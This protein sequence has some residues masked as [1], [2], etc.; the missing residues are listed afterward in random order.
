MLVALAAGIA[1]GTA[2]V[3]AGHF[4]AVASSGLLVERGPGV[5]WGALALTIL[6]AVLHEELLFRGYAFQKLLAWRPSAAI[7]ASSVTF[8]ALH[9]GNRDVGPIAL[10]NIALAGVLLALTFL[11]FRS[12]WAPIGA[13]LAWNVVSG[14]ILGHEVSGWDAPATLFETFDPGPAWI[15]G[16][17]FG[18]EGS[19]WMT[20]VQI[21]GIAALAWRIRNGPGFGPVDTIR[22]VTQERNPA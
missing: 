19:V 22:Y 18:I 7:V 12:L 20:L 3:V 1:I 10:V 8:A 21:A 9:G 4:A 11:L 17:E 13:H 5:P 15:T 14:P 6:P 16:G 2:A